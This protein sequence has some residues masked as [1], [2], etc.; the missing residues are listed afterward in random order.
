MRVRWTSPALSDLESIQDFVAAE[1]PVAASRLANR[2]HEAA[3]TWLSRAPMAGRPGRV[4]NTRE[5]VIAGT[6]YI[7]AYRIATEV[8]VLAVIHGAREWPDAFG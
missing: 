8:E 3:T 5:L 2:I 4:A 7:V 6:P 1:D